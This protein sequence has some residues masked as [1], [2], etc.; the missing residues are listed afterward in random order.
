MNKKLL[1]LALGSIL[2]APA[3]ALAQ[4]EAEDDGFSFSADTFSLD[5]APPEPP[6]VYDSYVEGGL[7]FNSNDSPRFGRFSGMNDNGLLINGKFR[8]LRRGEW[9]GEDLKYLAA[10]GDN[11]GLDSRRLSVSGGVQGKYKWL[12]KLQHIPYHDFTGH[13]PFTDDGGAHLRLPE[14]WIAN[15]SGDYNTATQQLPML[16]DSQ[17]AVALKTER[18]RYGGGVRWHFNTRWRLRLHAHNEDKEGA[19]PLGVAWGLSGQDAVAVIVAEPVDYRTQRV[20]AALDYRHA[21]QQWNLSYR[22]EQFDNNISRLRVD[23]PFA[24]NGWH[25]AASYPDAVADMQL[26]ADNQAHTLSLAGGYNFSAATRLTTHLAYARYSQDEALLGYTANPLLSVTENPPHGTVDAQLDITRF[27]LA[28]YSRPSQ[29]VD[30]KLRYRYKARDNQTSRSAYT[31]LIGDAEAQ[32]VGDG[33]VRYRLN[34]P[35]SFSENLLGGEV[36]YRFNKDTK[37]GLK[38]AY[39]DIERSYADR[40]ENTESTTRV[41][42]RKRFSPKLSS[43]FEYAH[44]KRRGSSYE[45]SSSLAHS[46]SKAYRDSLGDAAF[47]NHP[48]LRMYHVANRNRDTLGARLT[49]MPAEQA[50]LAASLRYSQDDYADSSLG[51]NSADL[52][53]LSLDGAYVVN[54]KLSLTAFYTWDTRTTEQSGWDFEGIAPLTQAADPNRRWWVDNEDRVH[55]LGF[56]LKWQSSDKLH[57]AADYTYTHA[58]TE[59]TSR[60]ANAASALPDA[61]TRIHALRSDLTY[62]LS[63]QMRL[64]ATYLF[65]HYSADNW[66]RDIAPDTLGRV[67]SLGGFEKDYANHVIL[68]W[69][70]YRF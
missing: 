8:Y 18:S 35:Y 36:H 21:K 66:Q 7:G 57:L 70:R 46:Y 24:Y 30:F 44:A 3:S 48:E 60:D 9:D 43:A 4:D 17:R 59:I 14:N 62:N 47:L 19:K 23:S 16:T 65:E 28:L 42:L 67:L 63:E 68:L 11:L 20:E 6:P 22:L 55:T 10:A 56:G 61:V 12:L 32:V 38:Q 26:A 41:S 15:D 49:A 34:T 29:A 31:Y 53:N 50:T 40:E 54:E 27:N 64:G 25:P 5:A 52:W 45:A 58:T 1:C 69:T 37:L 51:L 39:R 2:I 13:T 33:S